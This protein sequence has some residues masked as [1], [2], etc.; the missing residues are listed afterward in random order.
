M[1]KY[2]SLERPI[3]LGT[4]PRNRDNP[5]IAFE[6]FE[7]NLRCTKVMVTDNDKVFNAWG[8]MIF[9]NPLTKKDIVDYELGD[10]GAIPRNTKINTLP[11]A[12]RDEILNEINKFYDKAG[13]NFR[14]TKEGFDDMYGSFSLEDFHKMMPGIANKYHFINDKD[15]SALEKLMDGNTRYESIL[16]TMEAKETD[17]YENDDFER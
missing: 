9:K 1:Y 12:L 10:A 7:D 11:L 5:M 14:M 17:D 3:S 16:D 15:K 2:Y 13:S 8:Y 6:N 4:Y